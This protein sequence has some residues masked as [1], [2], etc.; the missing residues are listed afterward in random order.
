MEHHQDPRDHFQLIH[1]QREDRIFRRPEKQVQGFLLVLVHD[2]AQLVRQRKDQ[3]EVRDA[4][5]HLSLPQGYPPLLIQAAAARA[6]PVPAGTGT[7]FDP[8]AFPAADQRI[9]KFSGLAG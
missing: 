2:A 8:A 6:V 5:D 3:M 7:H 9:A 1:G 4:G